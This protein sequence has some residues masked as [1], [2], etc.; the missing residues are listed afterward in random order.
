MRLRM[1]IPVLTVCLLALGCSNDDTAS[2]AETGGP[3]STTSTTTTTVPLDPKPGSPGVDG[4]ALLPNAGNG[5][6]DVSHY[7]LAIAVSDDRSSIEATATIA[8][9]ATQDLSTFN[10]DLAG[11]DVAS[12]NVDDEPAGFSRNGDE[13]TVTPEE[14][15]ATDAEFVTRVEYSGAPQPVQDPSAPGTIG[16]LSAPSGI[17]VASEPIGAKGWFPGNDH[18]SDKARFTFEITAKNADTVVANGVL[19]SKEPAG[20]GRTTWT[21]EQSDEMATYLAQVA[22]GDYD[23][24]ESTG[25]N[26]LPIRHAVVRN[27]P[28][29]KREVLDLTAAQIEYFEPLFGPFPLDAYGL[30]VADAGPEFALETQT[31]TLLPASWLLNSDAE[32]TGMVMAHEL[33]H[34]WF[35]DAV[36]PARWTDIWLNEGFATYAE[37]MWEDHAGVTPLDESVTDAM[38]QAGRWREAFGPVA[39]PAAP[40]LFSPNSYEGAGIVL[41]ALRKTIGDEHFFEVLQRWASENDGESVTTEQFETLA[42]DVSGQDLTAFFAAWIHSDTLPVMPA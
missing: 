24:I 17:Y 41:H 34:Q 19:T 1:L 9:V 21:F 7:T 25:P 30:L 39:S 20:E 10:L 38:G 16:W 22:V 26:G 5:G 27:V 42:A 8:A 28:A 37:W 6:Y 29:D 40:L 36:T 32:F 33:A 14:A 15:L 18:P 13:L 23:L 31:L 3:S 35:G 12:V 2:P 11:L 4:E